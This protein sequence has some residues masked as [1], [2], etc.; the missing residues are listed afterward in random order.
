M[1][2]SARNIYR[3]FRI[4]RT[5]A[6]HDALFPLEGLGVAKGVIAPLRL[7]ARRKKDG[8]PGQRLARAMQELGPS[9]IKLG[10]ALSQGLT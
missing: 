3:L 1:F 9:F 5:L 10:Q 2:L 8:R 4:A 6:R 7:L